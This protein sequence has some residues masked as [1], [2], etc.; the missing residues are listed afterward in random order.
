MCVCVFGSGS[1]GMGV[2]QEK[3]KSI[4]FKAAAVT[5]YLSPLPHPILQKLQFTDTV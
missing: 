4:K 2:V 3:P 1:A 5:L